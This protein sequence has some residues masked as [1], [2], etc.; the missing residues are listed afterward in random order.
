M[1][2]NSNEPAAENSRIDL[3]TVTVEKLEQE[4]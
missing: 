3:N 1:N 4:M 2:V